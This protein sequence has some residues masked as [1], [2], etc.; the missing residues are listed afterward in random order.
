MSASEITDIN[1][2]AI[3][4]Y[5][6]SDLR[7]FDE[8]HYRLGLLDL[9][10]YQDLIRDPLTRLYYIR[11]NYWEY[12]DKDTFVKNGS[13]TSEKHT[14]GNYGVFFVIDRIVEQTDDISK[15]IY[16]Y[17]WFENVRDVE[18]KVT[19]IKALNNSYVCSSKVQHHFPSA[20]FFYNGNLFTLQI[21][22]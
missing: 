5:V 11:G 15:T 14:F 12:C 1:G 18:H 4:H 13:I 8:I 2:F 10:K 16:T 22:S 21:V 20:Y 9:N 19:K 6:S 7:T 3:V 17:T